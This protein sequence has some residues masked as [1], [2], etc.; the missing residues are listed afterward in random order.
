MTRDTD[1]PVA[2]RALAAAYRARM[3]HLPPGD[4]PDEQ[5]WVAFAAGEVDEAARV[6]MADHVVS[7]AACRDIYTVVCEIRDGAL[8]VDPGAPPS[9]DAAGASA[10]WRGVPV[11][12]A[13]AAAVALAVAGTVFYRAVR[14]SDA[15][16]MVANPPTV[17]APV[18]GAPVTPAAPEFR[19]A[20][21]K[22]AVQLPADL[23]VT[24]R[25]DEG[26]RARGF[27]ERFGRAI[28]PYN[29]GR[30]D[31]AATA[32]AALAS[33]DGDVAE[34]WF[35][36]GVAHLFAGRPAEALAAFD[37][38]GVA[39]AMG[40]DLRWQRAVALERLGRTGDLDA[41]LGDLCR[42]DGPYRDRACGAQ[43]DVSRPSPG[44]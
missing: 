21:I 37:H 18:A 38:P 11:W 24:T 40:D 9:R 6:R 4:H 2:D 36:L 22:P 20:M 33:T 29:D 44:R 34:V 25:G 39:G 19:L 23:V 42:R 3:Q 16:T 17:A 15:P 5:A 26:A 35:Y 7:C 28:A 12:M 14:P 31:E 41:V 1:M 32:L 27:L 43:R 30:F 8:A 10:V 13:L